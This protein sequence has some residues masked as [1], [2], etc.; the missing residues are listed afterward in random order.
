MSVVVGVLEAN[1]ELT[2]LLV[3]TIT[4]LLPAKMVSGHRMTVDCRISALTCV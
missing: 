2:A 3:T 1:Y 4:P